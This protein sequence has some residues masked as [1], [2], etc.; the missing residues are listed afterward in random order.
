VYEKTRILA[1]S[2][3]AAPALGTRSISR[4]VI[5]AIAIAGLTFVGAN[6]Y[7]PLTPVPVTL[8]TLF[9]L[10]AGA[11]IGG[12]FGS[13]S[14]LL[15]VGA[16]AVGLPIFAGGLA[17]GAVLAG[18]TGGYLL[19]F[20]VVPLVVAALIRRSRSIAWLTVSYTVGT[21]VIFAMGVTHLAVF[22]TGSF[23]EAL[24]VGLIPFLPGAALKIVAA[25]SITRSYW[26]LCEHRRGGAPSR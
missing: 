14:Q 16:G 21:I 10:M 13:L 4:G 18:P 24:K 8:Q 11:A 19:S 7:I 25:T 23:G 15:Y 22:Y 9:V 26:A 12:R 1:P 6:I 2:G 5:G 20:F 17:G 3:V